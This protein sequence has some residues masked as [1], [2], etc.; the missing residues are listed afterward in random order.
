MARA[1]NISAEKIEELGAIISE[2][3]KV[4]LRDRD[5][6]DLLDG[7]RH[8]KKDFVKKLVASNC[9]WLWVQNSLVMFGAVGIEGAAE[10]LA[11]YEGNLESLKNL[12]YRLYNICEKKNWSKE[13]TIY[14]DLVI[15]WQDILTARLNYLSE[16]KPKPTEPSLF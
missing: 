4:R 3:G 6:M 5:E 12:A 16:E 13:G 9:A 1:K 10:L 14:N 11:A 2:R 15:E 8:L 7:N